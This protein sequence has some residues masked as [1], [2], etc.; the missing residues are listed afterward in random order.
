[1]PPYV[2]MPT[3]AAPMITKGNN[4]QH[5]LQN[6][7]E[8][9]IREA[10]MNMTPYLVALAL[11]FVAEGMT[12]YIFAT[13]IDL[14][15]A[16]WPQIKDAKPLKYIAAV[17]GVWFSFSYS[18]DLIAAMLGVAPDPPWIGILLTGLML[19]RGSNYIHDFAQQYL[20]LNA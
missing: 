18:L 3:I 6:E 16:K 11:A 10:N 8:V 9:Q 12:E 5:Y 13:W 4:V 7:R 2:P 20:G 1:M 14:A 17:V 19:G 15:A